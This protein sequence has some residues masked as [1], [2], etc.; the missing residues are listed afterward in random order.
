M[1]TEELFQIVLPSGRCARFV[2]L[3]VRDMQ[4]MTIEVRKRIGNRA[5]APELEVLLGNE[6]VARC[7]RAITAP[8]PK[9]YREIELQAPASDEGSIL[10]EILPA[11]KAVVLQRVR[12]DDAMLA[13]ISPDEWAAAA[14]TYR[15][16]ITRNGPKSIDALLTVRDFNALVALMADPHGDDEVVAAGKAQ[17]VTG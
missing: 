5:N 15:E 2:G 7:T 13:A 11:S 16:L 3:T 1:A 6:M 9:L 17:M 4:T 14:V 8:R 10:D 12:D